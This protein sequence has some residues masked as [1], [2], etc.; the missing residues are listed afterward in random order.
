[1][2]KYLKL[3]IVI[4]I[5]L[6]VAFAAL[7]I[8][9][10]MTSKNNKPLNSPEISDS[11]A[12][13]AIEW[14]FMSYANNDIDTYCENLPQ[15]IKDAMDDE[16]FKKYVKALVERGNEFYGDNVE[17][18]INEEKTVVEKQRRLDIADEVNMVYTDLFDEFDLEYENI[19]FVDGYEFLVDIKSESGENDRKGLK[20]LTLKTKDGGWIVWQNKFMEIAGLPCEY[21]YYDYERE[22]D[23]D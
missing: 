3:L 10:Y 9:D 11:T 23:L 14:L 22:Y 20:V 21:D 6:G 17:I 2:K 13:N 16:D 7:K 5:F 12:Q 1:M 19:S 8:S 15:E 18:D 4:V